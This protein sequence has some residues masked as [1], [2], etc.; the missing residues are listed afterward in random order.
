[1][2]INCVLSSWGI[3]AKGVKGINDVRLRQVPVVEEK[4]VTAE[5]WL[6]INNTNGD[7][8][9]KYYVKTHSLISKGPNG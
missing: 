9:S 2:D 5:L 1:M 3:N 7:E 6:F 4:K 8:D